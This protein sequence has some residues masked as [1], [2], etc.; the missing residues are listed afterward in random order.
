MKPQDR[1]YQPDDHLKVYD[2]VWVGGDALNPDLVT[3]ETVPPPEEEEGGE[4]GIFP[5]YWWGWRWYEH[6]GFRDDR[7]EAFVDRAELGVRLL[8]I[9]RRRNV[10]AAG[11]EQPIEA[12]VEAAPG[13]LAQLEGD[14]RRRAAG[15]GEGA[16]V[17]EALAIERIALPGGRDVPAGDK[18]NDRNTNRSCIS[19]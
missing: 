19:G 4:D 8:T 7:V 16:A 15:Q 2:N 14:Q 3:S 17:G 12:A 5:R 6:E 1:W 9:E 10:H 13:G 11:Q 18:T